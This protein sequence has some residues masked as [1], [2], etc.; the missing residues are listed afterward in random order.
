MRW[1]LLVVTAMATT[2][3]DVLQ[4]RGM[5]QH[6]EIRDFRPGALAGVLRRVARN[7]YVIA[8]IACFAVSFFAFLGL[9]SIS[10]L[11]FAVPA[12]AATYVVETVFAKYL[13]KERV[14]YLRWLGAVL[15][16]C[17]VVLIGL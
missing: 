5:K 10:P 14:T 9:L 16:A 4:S 3:G 13:L 7:R 15:V 11:S 8:A 2:A 1:V 17:G 6:G 12:T